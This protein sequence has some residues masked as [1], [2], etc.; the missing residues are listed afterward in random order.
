MAR[1][2][3]NPVLPWLRAPVLSISRRAFKGIPSRRPMT[4]RRMLCCRMVARSS[5]MYCSSSCMRKSSSSAGRFQFSLEKQYRVSWW[6]PSRGHSSVTRWTLATPRRWASMR[7]RP[8]RWAHR[9]PRDDCWHIRP[10]SWRRG[11]RLLAPGATGPLGRPCA[12]PGKPTLRHFAVGPAAKKGSL[13]P[14]RTRGGGWPRPASPGPLV[15]TRPSVGIAFVV[16]VPSPRWFVAAGSVDRDQPSSAGIQYPQQAAVTPRRMRHREPP[17]HG[18]PRGDVDHT[19]AVGL[20]GP[21]ALRLVRF[22]MRRNK[23]GKPFFHRQPIQ[24]APVLRRQVADEGRSPAR[25]ETVAIFQRTQTRKQGVDQPQSALTPSHLVPVN[26]ARHER[27]P[28]EPAAVMRVERWYATGQFVG[29]V[30]PMD[31][32]PRAHGKPHHPLEVVEPKPQTTLLHAHDNQLPRLIRGHQKR[33]TQ[34]L[35][36]PRKITRVLEPH[37]A[38]ARRCSA[39]RLPIVACLVGRHRIVSLIPSRTP[40]NYFSSGRNRTS[41]SGPLKPSDAFKG[42]IAMIRGPTRRDR[43][44]DLVS[45]CGATCTK[46]HACDTP[47]FFGHCPP[48]LG[49]FFTPVPVCQ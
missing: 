42:I 1:H 43:H 38:D 37:F 11:A 41:A 46:P 34:M 45:T 24:I 12:E 49:A 5:T 10:R 40:P 39:S 19:T 21:P 36:N 4:E 14:G 2:T 26:V 29:R 18:L 27:T 15:A 48:S 33:C 17:R 28:H 9:P 47:L 44:Q 32:P 6:M 23:P 25:H 16:R 13:P 31:V 7:G 35:Q 8:W 3:C 30:Q 22:S 20:V